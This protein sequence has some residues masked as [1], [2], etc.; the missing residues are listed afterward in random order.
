MRKKIKT[1]VIGVGVMGLNHV[2][3][4]AQI[5]KLAAVCD[6]DVGRGDKVASRYG[7]RFY[8]DYKKMLDKEEIGVVIVA[9]PTRFHR[10]VVIDCLKRKI[11]TLVEKPIAGSL[12]GAEKIVK[13]AEKNNVFLMVGHVERFNPAVIKLKELIDK[14]RLGRIVNLLAVRVGIKPPK[15]RNFDVAV[16]LGIHDVDVFNY[17]VGKYP[18]KK[19]VI[20]TRIYDK[21]IADSASILLKYKNAVGL[22]Q[23][24]WITPVKIRKLYVTG[25]KGFSELDY[26]SQ[27]LV[28]YDRLLLGKKVYV[29]RKEPLEK[30][31]EYFLKKKKKGY[32][33]EVVKP[34]VEALK[35][36]S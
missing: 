17:L 30:E 25:T 31:L 28:I 34:A 23:T 3:V 19:T 18:Y 14:G 4:L 32:L 24:N 15:G 35:I 36:L 13:E 7:V 20:R 33:S 21:N 29:M 10:K 11:A 8:R 9:V 1:A 6:I 12:D 5:S 2:R 22:V 26:I 27:K 16:D